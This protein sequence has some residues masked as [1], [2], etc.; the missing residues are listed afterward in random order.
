M[1]LQFHL[2]DCISYLS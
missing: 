1:L 2:E